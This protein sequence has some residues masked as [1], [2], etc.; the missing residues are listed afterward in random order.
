MLRGFIDG[1]AIVLPCYLNE[2][3]AVEIDV[4]EFDK[5]SVSVSLQVHFVWVINPS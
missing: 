3:M 2:V 1:T 5:I 4:A